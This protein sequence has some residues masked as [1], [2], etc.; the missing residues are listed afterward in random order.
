MISA[1]NSKIV[2]F[3]LKRSL[4]RNPHQRADFAAFLNPNMKVGLCY[5]FYGIKII[6]YS[7]ASRASI[8]DTAVSTYNK[9]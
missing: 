5:V 1:Q 4:S 2:Y 3:T 6:F 7:A 8:N 9:F